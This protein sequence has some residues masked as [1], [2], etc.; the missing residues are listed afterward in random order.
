MNLISL[1]KQGAE[2]VPPSIG[3]R[4]AFVDY[5]YRLGRSYSHIKQS[6][7]KPRSRDYLFCKVKVLV[8]QSQS[9]IPFY[10]DFYEEK[11]FDSSR[12]S[13]FGDLV[14][15]PI[16][17]KADLQKYDFYDRVFGNGIETN[18][19][20]TSGQPL[21]L[22][23]DGN[24]YAREWAHMHAIWE[25]L[26]YKTT[27][28]KLTFRGMNLGNRTIKYNFVHNEF[29]VNAYCGFDQ[30]VSSLG[31]V[32]GRYSIEYLHGYPS[33]IF[34]FL[35]R[36]E[37]VDFELLVKLRAN[38][39]GVFFGSE[40]PAPMYRDYIE[41][42]LNVSTISWYGHSEM[43]VLSPEIDKYLYAPFQSYGYA[44]SVEIDGK[45]HLVGT[46]YNN[47][48]GPLIRY[49]TGDIIEPVSYN[50]GILE[51][52]R[53]S[54]GRIG[55]IVIDR[56]GRRISLTALIF[57]RHH[58]LFEYV[59]FIQVSQKK[60]GHLTV[61]VTSSDQSLVCEDLFDGEGMSMNINFKIVKINVF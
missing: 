56:N 41:A 32:L 15:I 2:L 6:V 19:G 20:G 7:L 42:I 24:A 38:L 37:Q 39:K 30:L 58:K 25:R 47:S 36:L 44:E 17:T 3:T 59:D 45:Q 61:I 52:F 48:V 35:K 53:I 57:G 43:A 11:G 27:S 4:L 21:K 55:E 40:Y 13:C 34:E 1:I 12:L 50:D 31:K 22:M 60:A 10:R 28:P 33:G 26:G 29:Q 54:E 5:N 16:V 9:N 14:E 46:T 8:K 49:D 23:L 51:A 18:T